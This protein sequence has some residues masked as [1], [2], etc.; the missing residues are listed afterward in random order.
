MKVTRETYIVNIPESVKIRE[1]VFEI[2]TDWMVKHNTY[3]G[4]GVMQC[5]ICIISAP[6]LLAD[7]IDDIIKPE[8]K[9]NE[10]I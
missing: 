2:I 8:I 6:V 7:I 1:E 4:E 5:D 9:E 10:N 3:S